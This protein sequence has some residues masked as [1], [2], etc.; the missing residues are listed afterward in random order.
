MDDKTKPVKPRGTGPTRDRFGWS[1]AA[2]RMEQIGALEQKIIELKRDLV[3]STSSSAFGPLSDDLTFLMMRVKRKFVAV[4]VHHVE[5][6]V[7]MPAVAPLYDKGSA[8]LGLLD[9][10]G[11]TV[12]VIDFAVL[13][14]M[15][16]APVTPDKALVIFS[17]RPYLFAVMIDEPTDV[18]TVSQRA[19]RVADEVLPG[20]ISSIGVLRMTGG[21]SVLLY[22]VGS[23]AHS[24]GLERIMKSLESG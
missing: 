17:L 19:I 9:Y 4:P 14:G 24:V 18:V 22:D 12:A 2:L 13:L 6:V 8:V 11:N 16:N 21:G 23:I 7:Q 10:H 20:A 5:E 3:L 1:D 15:N